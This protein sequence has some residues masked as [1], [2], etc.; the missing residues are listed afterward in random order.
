MPAPAGH[1]AIAGGFADEHH[2]T[3]DDD[4]G[5]VG[6]TDTASDVSAEGDAYADTIANT[7]SD[8]QTPTEVGAA[9]DEHY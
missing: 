4:L 9:V 8:S 5:G 3:P 6:D 7:S 2:R 1:P